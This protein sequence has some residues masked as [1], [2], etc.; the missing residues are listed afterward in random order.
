MI[1]L[2]HRNEDQRGHGSCEWENPPVN[3]FNFRPCSKGW[4]SDVAGSHKRNGTL[5]FTRCDRRY[6][7]TEGSDGDTCMNGQWT[8]MGH[9][10]IRKSSR[11]ILMSFFISADSDDISI[12]VSYINLDVYTFKYWH[13]NLIIMM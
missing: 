8:S 5:R 4:C 10:C 12:L 6:V 13:L 11:R 7:L 1:L 3:G 2:L 9:Q